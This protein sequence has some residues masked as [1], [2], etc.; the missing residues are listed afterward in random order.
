MDT[1]TKGTVITRDNYV[2]VLTA[3][4]LAGLLK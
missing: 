3:H 1:R 2:S 4:G